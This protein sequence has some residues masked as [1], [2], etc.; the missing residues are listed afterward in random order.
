[1]IGVSEDHSGKGFSFFD[2]D[3]L[4]ELVSG[5][6][7]FFEELLFFAILFDKFKVFES[8]VLLENIGFD[9]FPPD[10]VKIIVVCSVGKVNHVG[11]E[12]IDY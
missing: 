3:S 10:V 1:M 6:E 8:I 9:E 4:K 5:P 2:F 12:S 11:S 7:L